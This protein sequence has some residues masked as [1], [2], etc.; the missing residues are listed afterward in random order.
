MPRFLILSCLICMNMG[1]IA[2]I[3]SDRRTPYFFD[4]QSN[5]ETKNYYFN[6]AERFSSAV[7]TD[8]PEGPVRSMA[9][10]E[11]QQAVVLT[12]ASD[13]P[14][15]AELTRLLKDDVE[16]III[17][18]NATTVNSILNNLDIDTSENVR[19]IE[20]EFNSVWVRDYGPNSAYLN[21]VDSLILIDWIYNRP[22]RTRDD[23]LSE[24]IS[25]E[26]DIPLY[27]TV[28]EPFRLV[29]TGGNYMADGMGQSFSSELVVEE[30]PLLGI[31]GVD[32]VLREY[33][34][35][36]NYIKFE[37]LPYDNIHH[38]DMHMKI[39][40][41]QRILVGQY[42]EDIADGPQIEANIQ[43]LLDNFT[44]SFG[45]PFEIIRMPMPPD[46][47][48]LY[49]HQGADYRTYVNA[50][51]ANKTIVVPTYEEQYDI[52]ALDL[53]REIMPGYNIQGI[54][55]NGIIPKSGALH[56]ITKEVG[57]KAPLRIVHEK[58]ECIDEDDFQGFEAIIQ[59]RSGIAEAKLNLKQK[60]GTFVS[61]DLSLSD[62]VNHLWSVPFDDV[63]TDQ[64]DSYEYYFSATANSGKVIVRP[65]VA[66]EGLFVSNSCNLVSAIKLESS[67]NKLLKVFPNPAN[68]L[69]C[70]PVKFTQTS[71][72][73]ISIMDVFGKEV[74]NVYEGW[75]YEGEKKYFFN[76][77]ELPQAMYYVKLQE[78]NNTYFQKI[79]V[80]K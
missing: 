27:A 29:A 53:W 65:L 46:N 49:P 43:F 9:E 37:N 1:L 73:S 30:N 24:R 10:W 39:I 26:L 75:F 18:N 63:T 20:D 68:S 33:M 12:W 51:I 62:P 14:I 77:N 4:I 35:V 47:N 21:D 8:P 22:F 41:E 6:S 17:C 61:T 76:A 54:N 36:E 57:V 60:D 13:F 5:K 59:H 56:C 19:I 40:D 11:E 16:V 28:N 3:D 58:P 52:P 55:C 42:P 2:Q 15:L 69:T 79:F 74:L 50:Y 45:K 80:G 31:D 67:E 34:G 38:I 44:N 48:G 72:G 71:S 66:P 64:T 70:I 7:I 32:E 25:E 23:V 78:G